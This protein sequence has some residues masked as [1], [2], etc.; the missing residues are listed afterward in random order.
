M[1]NAEAVKELVR[2]LESGNVNVSVRIGA[3]EGLGFTGFTIA[4]EALHKMATSNANAEIRAAAARALGQ[5]VAVNAA[6]NE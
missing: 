6:S 4:K 1:K 2:L 3:A 5:A